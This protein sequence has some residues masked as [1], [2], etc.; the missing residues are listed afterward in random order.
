VPQPPRSARIVPGIAAGISP[1]ALIRLLRQLKKG[2]R[3]H[4]DFGR[5]AAFTLTKDMRMMLNPASD[6]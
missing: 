3:S 4:A 6:C 5:K 2:K 1:P